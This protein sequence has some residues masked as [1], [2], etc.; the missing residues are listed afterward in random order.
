MAQTLNTRLISRNDSTANWDAVASSA[1]LE[2]GEIGVEILEN[3]KAKIKIGNGVEG[4]STWDQLSYVGGEAAHVF[5]VDSLDSIPTDVELAIGDIAIVK[6]AIYED[7]TDIDKNRYSYTGYVYKEVNDGLAWV[8]M[9]GNYNAT[10]VYFS[11]DITLAGSY[12]AVGNVT[13]SSNAA[14]GTLAAAG[15]SLAEVMTSIFTKELYPATGSS[16]NLPTISISASGG[17]GEVGSTYTLPTATLKID[18]VGAYT[19]GPATGIK[20]EAGEVTLAQGALASATNKVSNENEMVANSTITL[21]AQDTSNV[22]T[23]TTKT[24][25]FNASGDYIQGA[26]PVTNV[27][28]DYPAARIDAGTATAT[29]KS[30]TFSG[31]RYM[32]A[33][34]TTSSNINSTAIRALSSTRKT[35][36]GKPTTSSYFEFTAV[37]GDTKVIFAYP[38]SI[39]GT[40]K[41]EI[42]TMAW[43]ATEGFEESTVSVAGYNNNGNETDYK[44]F[45]YTPATPLAADSTKYRV[46]F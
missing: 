18:D 31:W 11:D 14:T 32:F 26:M 37:K 44:V 23:D 13:K 43:G 8:A 24:Y 30:V 6:T 41:F 7:E 4:K 39:T 19:Y 9:D 27:G 42:F 10:N 28:N 12:T 16:R 45:T 36:D 34:G 2:A 25:T 29:E 38:A 35:S 15:K 1:V 17:N 20:F 22:Y 3:G 5:E 40:P 21:T 46:Y 33:G